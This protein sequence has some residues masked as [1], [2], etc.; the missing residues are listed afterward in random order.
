MVDVDVLVIGGGPSGSTAAA[1]LAT[2]GKK[3]VLV[4]RDV[5][6]RHHIGEALQP[7]AIEMLDLH[8]GQGIRER[9]AALGFSRKYGATYEWGETSDRWSILFDPRLEGDLP[10]LTKET[11]HQGG[12]EYTWHVERDRFDTLLLTVAKERGVT[13]LRAEAVR[14]LVDGDRVDGLELRHPDGRTEEVRAR[15]VI[16]ASGQRCF[17]ARRF[18]VV[19]NV[20][21]MKAIAVYGYFHGA[22]GI[23]GALDRWVTL[24]ASTAEG[25]CWFIPQSPT[26]TSVGYVTHDAHQHDEQGFLDIL[27]Q[28]SLPLNGATLVEDGGERVRVVRNWSYQVGRIAG[29]GWICCGDAAGFVDPILSGGVEFAVRGACNAAIAVTKILDDGWDAEEVRADYQKR[30]FEERDAYLSLARYWYGNNRSVQGFFWE[31]HRAIKADAI[32][33]DTPLRAFFYLTTGKFDADR[34]YKVFIEWQERRIFDNLGVDKRALK[35]A[36][37]RARRKMLNPHVS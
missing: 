30:L 36:I 35:E 37:E 3:V 20:E 32:S 5:F 25:W 13:V 33:I 14:P 27:K 22:G 29:P 19:K 16:D 26:R 23:D 18:G 34:H 28:S 9:I 24:I 7:A 17:L 11:I 6:P 4:E 10:R 1:I 15:Q 8:L 2:Q 31:A 21:D 12:Y